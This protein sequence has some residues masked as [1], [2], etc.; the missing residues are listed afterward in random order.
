MSIGRKKNKLN[1]TTR[2]HTRTPTAPP[3][4]KSSPKNINSISINVS[5]NKET[6]HTLNFLYF[7]YPIVLS[8]HNPMHSS[9]SR[10]Y[11][12]HWSGFDVVQDDLE[13]MS[14]NVLPGLLEESHTVNHTIKLTHNLKSLMFGKHGSKPLASCILSVAKKGNLLAQSTRY[15]WEKREL[16]RRTASPGTHALGGFFTADIKR[17][18]KHEK[19]MHTE[20][21]SW[22]LNIF[23]W[24]IY[25]HFSLTP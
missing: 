1:Q 4:K 8:S 12:E 13:F 9:V 22:S 18:W 5:G 23:K 17:P 7:F 21:E 14:R 2:A 20:A 24:Y 3:K 11:T 10:Q 15:F 19:V 25:L 16:N 6:M